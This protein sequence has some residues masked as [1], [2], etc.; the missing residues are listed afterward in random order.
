[1]LDYLSDNIKP[2]TQPGGIFGDGTNGSIRVHILTPTTN[3]NALNGAGDGSNGNF[4]QE[5]PDRIS[6]ITTFLNTILPKVPIETPFVY[7][8]QADDD[9]FKTDVYFKAMVSIFRS[10]TYLLLLVNLYIDTL[11]R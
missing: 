11:Q 10:K 5:Y 9:L 8:R 1:M 7:Q 6:Q 3:D 2:L 4:P